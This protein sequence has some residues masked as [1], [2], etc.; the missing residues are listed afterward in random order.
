MHISH[1]YLDSIRNVFIT[2]ITCDAF[3]GTAYS[4]SEHLA[5]NKM[6]VQSLVTTHL[7]PWRYRCRLSVRSATVL[8]QSPPHDSRPRHPAAC[9]DITFSAPVPTGSPESAPTRTTG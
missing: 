9:S 6:Y 8:L 5:V 2:F 1:R 4:E 3:V 7:F